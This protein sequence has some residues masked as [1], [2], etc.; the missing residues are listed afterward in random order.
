MAI[1]NIH[2]NTSQEN[3]NLINEDTIWH[4]LLSDIST[5]EEL[6]PWKHK[7]KNLVIKQIKE[8]I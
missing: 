5:K 8:N 4:I 3:K 6:I 7:I 1:L 2:L